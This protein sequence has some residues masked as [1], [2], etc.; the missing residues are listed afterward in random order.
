L[1]TIGR[2]RRPRITITLNPNILTQVDRLVDRKRIRNRSHAI[3]YLVS[4]IFQPQVKQAVILAGG[5]GT[6]LRP[7]TYELPKSLLPIKGKPLMEHLIKRLK[8]NGI[9]EIIVCLGYLGE[10]IKEHFGNGEKFGV[11][12]TYSEEKKPLQTGG[13]LLNVKKYIHKENPFLVI[14]GDLLTDCPFQDVFDFH[15][16]EHAI[17]TITLTSVNHPTDFGQLKLHGTKLVNFYQKSDAKGI[18]SHLVNCGI[19]VFEPTIF[20]SFPKNKSAFLLEDVIENLI[21]Q[22]RVSGFV[23]EGQWFD[24]GTPTHYEQAI[25]EFKT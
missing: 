18:K 1:S 8:E 23:F 3:E 6:H 20:E 10:K 25:K 19:Y 22:K 17:A 9:D 11:K 14:H 13:A 12:I 21:K 2:M 7:Y 16:Q 24:V 15:K 5:Q 4:Q